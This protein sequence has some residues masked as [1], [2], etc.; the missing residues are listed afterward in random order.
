MT[1]ETYRRLRTRFVVGDDW[2]S[3]EKSTLLE[4][5]DTL[6]AA[7]RQCLDALDRAHDNFDPV[8]GSC[9]MGRQAIH[10]LMVAAADAAR[11]LA[12]KE[13]AAGGGWVSRP[14]P[15]G[16]LQPVPVDA[17]MPGYTTCDECARLSRN[18]TEAERAA[19][20]VPR[21]ANW[22]QPPEHHP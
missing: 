13:A 2:S 10:D 4:E 1:N 5:I 16:H 12:G 21:P 18:L 20:V 19:V 14:M 17:P 15:C 9:P 11:P 22:N 3:S 6:R 7:L 8:M